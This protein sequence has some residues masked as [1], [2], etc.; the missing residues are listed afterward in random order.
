MHTLLSFLRNQKFIHT[1]SDPMAH[2][3]LSLLGISFAHSKS[4]SDE[5][6]ALHPGTSTSSRE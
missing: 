2:C 5:G 6:T 4:L 1:S 3:Y